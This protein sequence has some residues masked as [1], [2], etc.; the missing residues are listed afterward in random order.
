PSDMS[1]APLIVFLLAGARLASGTI[2]AVEVGAQGVRPGA[3]LPEVAGEREV[4][5]ATPPEC[6]TAL[7]QVSD[8]KKLAAIVT[9]TQKVN[10]MISFAQALVAQAKAMLDEDR[11]LADALQTNSTGH[12]NQAVFKAGVNTVPNQDRLQLKINELEAEDKVFQVAFS[13]VVP[14]RVT[15]LGA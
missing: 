14:L 15:N 7:A 2:A 13:D 8:A 3:P 12:L 6:S 10:N 5:C 11:Y 4:P 1:L 9:T